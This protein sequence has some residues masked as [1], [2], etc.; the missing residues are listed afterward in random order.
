MIKETNK[1]K[2][3]DIQRLGKDVVEYRDGKPFTSIFNHQKACQ[4]LAEKLN[5]IIG[6]I[7]KQV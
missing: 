4:E 3:I 6:V 7:N 5:E 2:E 1:I